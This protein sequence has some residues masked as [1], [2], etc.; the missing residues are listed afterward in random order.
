[1]SWSPFMVSVAVNATVGATAAAAWVG[2]TSIPGVVRRFGKF[3][4]WVA[5]LVVIGAARIVSPVVLEGV[6]KQLLPQ[7]TEEMLLT[8][9]LYQ[10]I[11]RQEP[12][13]FQQLVVKASD[14]LKK[15]PKSSLTGICADSVGKLTERRLP[16]ASDKAV[17]DFVRSNVDVM[18]ALYGIKPEYAY[19]F[20]FPQLAK[21]DYTYASS[22][23]PD[24]M[25]KQLAAM[26]QVLVS[27][28]GNT[29]IQPTKEEADR[30]IQEV[31]DSLLKAHGKDVAVLGNMKAP[32]VDRGKCAKLL[33][34]YMEQVLA[35]PT[36]KAVVVYRYSFAG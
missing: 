16:K 13:V 7:R 27:S 15:D 19:L 35:L 34:A 8:I 28:N 11:K 20:V 6:N 21:G 2:F 29:P 32:D 31:V 9:P 25:Q 10:E 18:K 36:E 3:P 30:I 26:N 22:I 23:P 14:A 24:L 5:I 33:I 12:A 1:M 17:L 4:S